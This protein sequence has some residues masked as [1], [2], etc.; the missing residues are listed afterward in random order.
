MKDNL[1]TIL[2]AFANNPDVSNKFDSAPLFKDVIDNT[3]N[4]GSRFDS[5]PLFNNIF[6]NMPE[7]ENFRLTFNLFY[8]QLYNLYF[9]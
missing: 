4:I 6:T 1:T 7:L 9:L 2:E 3:P 5:A 8:R